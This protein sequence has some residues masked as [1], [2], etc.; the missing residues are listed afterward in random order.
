MKVE[1][2][3]TDFKIPEVFDTLMVEGLMLFLRKLDTRGHDPDS[4]CYPR[5]TVINV[6]NLR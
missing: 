1:T 2:I 5:F 3:L 6:R 4:L